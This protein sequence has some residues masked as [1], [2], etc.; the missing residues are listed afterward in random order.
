MKVSIYFND[1]VKFCIHDYVHGS[2]KGI[3]GM[4]LH[5]QFEIALTIEV[6][7]VLALT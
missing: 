7:G 5:S 6:N 1:V 2:R 4:N 3:G